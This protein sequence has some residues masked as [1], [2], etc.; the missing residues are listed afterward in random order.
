MELIYKTFAIVLLLCVILEATRKPTQINGR[1]KYRYNT[2]VVVLFAMVLM[3]VS[4]FRYKFIDTGDYRLMYEAI[5]PN[6]DN[7]FNGTVE[8]VETGYLFFTYLLNCISTD[9][10]FLLIVTSAIVNAVYI[11]KIYKYSEDLPFSLFLYFTLSYMGTMNGIRQ[12]LAAAL[13]L[14]VFEWC[15]KRK[16][17]P[18]IA[19]ILLLMTIHKSVVILIPV[20]FI[21]R[22]KFFNAGVKGA[23]VF[24]VLMLVMP[25]SVTSLLESVLG[26]SDYASYLSSTEG[27]NIMRF[28]VACVPT[29]LIVLYCRQTNEDYNADPIMRCLMNLC[30]IDLC[31][32]IMAIR[33]LFFGRICMYFSICKLVLIPTLIRRTFPVKTA[34]KVKLCAVVLYSV[35]FAYQIYS[36]GGYMN[37]FR[38]IF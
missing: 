19:L 26:D 2:F 8:R 21:V 5:G 20:Y 3:F 13:A 31:A 37:N 35:Y 15:Y 9:S 17:I 22:N 24:S 16:T 1:F 36:Y 28:F 32:N 38:L 18:Y 14:I 23:L 11:R 34:F 29:V 33:I 27:M 25:G 10:Q 30:I 7:V 12:T 6:Y 4:G